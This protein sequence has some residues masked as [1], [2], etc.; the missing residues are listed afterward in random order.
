VLAI[1]LLAFP[2][3][4]NSVSPSS[5]PGVDVLAYLVGD[6]SLWP[7][8]GSHGQHQVVDL[9]RR[10]VC[11]VKYGN[12]RRFE[13]WRW[14]EQYV[15]HA[16]DHA[17]DGDSNDSYMFTDGRWLPRFLPA[18]A[19][20][21][22]PWTLDVAANR[23]VWFDAACAVDPVRSHGFPY[24]MRAWIEPR[25]DAG[26]DLGV[27]ETLLFDYEPY[28]PAAAAPGARERFYFGRGAGWY[29]WERSGFFDYFNRVGGF[30]VVM[31]RQVWCAGANP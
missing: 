22:S 19:T 11:W 29:E 18:T 17:L 23:I 24:R 12:P 10:E 31:N 2:A 7:R 28:D 15:Y 26:P 30:P 13:C 16:V 3:C 8:R 9:A 21:A 25:V 14:D 27:R 1:V 20:A 5:P 6:A 4:A